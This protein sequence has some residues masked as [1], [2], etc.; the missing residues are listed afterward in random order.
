MP[1]AGEYW[2]IISGALTLNTWHKLHEAITRNNQCRGMASL[3]VRVKRFMYTVS[4]LPGN[5]YETV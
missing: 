4:S 3:L 5:S 2:V 1:I